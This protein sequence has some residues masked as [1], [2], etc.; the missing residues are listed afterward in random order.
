MFALLLQLPIPEEDRNEMRLKFE[1]C[2]HEN[3]E[4]RPKIL[5]IFEITT[6]EVY[7]KKSF[8]IDVLDYLRELPLLASLH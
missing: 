8:R 2:F 4:Q 7:K 3:P 1:D 6:A 5:H